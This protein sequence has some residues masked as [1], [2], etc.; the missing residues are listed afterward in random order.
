MIKRKAKYTIGDYVSRSGVQYIVSSIKRSEDL[1][2]FI[3]GLRRVRD[4]ASFVDNDEKELNEPNVE[5]VL[6]DLFY[7]IEQLR[8]LTTYYHKKCEAS[9]QI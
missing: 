8:E 6:D 1:E 5:K 3:Y 7:R 4:D 2:S 9:E